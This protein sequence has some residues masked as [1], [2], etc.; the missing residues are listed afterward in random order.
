MK[1]PLLMQQQEDLFLAL[2]SP[3][4]APNRILEKLVGFLADP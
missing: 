4:A 3:D 1:V 2:Q